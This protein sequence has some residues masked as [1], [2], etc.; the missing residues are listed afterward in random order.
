MLGLLPFVPST[1]NSC[2][3]RGGESGTFNTMVKKKWE[4]AKFIFI[5]LSL[6]SWGICR[7]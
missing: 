2:V 1:T 7:E 4:R 3:F 6:I 5:A